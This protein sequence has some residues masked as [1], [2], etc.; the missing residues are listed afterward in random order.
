MSPVTFCSPSFFAISF[1]FIIYHGFDFAFIFSVY[2]SCGN[3]GDGLVIGNV[4]VGVKSSA[5]SLVIGIRLAFLFGERTLGISLDRALLGAEILSLFV[6]TGVLSL[7]C[8]ASIFSKW[9]DFR[10][11]AGAFRSWE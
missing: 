1:G 7:E 10:E 8:L 5:G 4:L 3:R 6:S 9:F 11:I 2:G